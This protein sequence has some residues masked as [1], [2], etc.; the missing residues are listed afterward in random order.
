MQKQ[1][2]RS[3]IKNLLPRLDKSNKYHPK[4]IDSAIEKVLGE[5]YTE[6]F[7]RNSMELQR[8]CKPYGYTTALTVNLEPAT[9]L[10]YTTLPAAIYPFPDKS[11]GVRRVSTIVQGGLTFFPIDQRE[12][13]LIL[14]GSNVDAVTS[15]IGYTVTSTR[16]EFYNMS[17]TVLAAGV[18]MD[19]IVPFSVY[20]DT[21]TVLIPEEK[22]DQGRTFIDRVLAIL[23]IVRP[24]DALDNNADVQPTNNS[25]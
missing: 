25:Q 22:D 12:H 16:V 7:K 11:S 2:I 4:V 21:D 6:V 14:S 20:S 1:E 5:I 19:C 23:G 9:G 15:K 3:L 17:G 13:D 8:Y 24:I 18:R 10:Y